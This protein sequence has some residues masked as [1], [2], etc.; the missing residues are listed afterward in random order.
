MELLDETAN[1][2]GSNMENVDTEV[3]KLQ[4]Q[5][6]KILEKNGAEASDQFL[7]SLYQQNALCQAPRSWKGRDVELEPMTVLTEMKLKC[8]W[9]CAANDTS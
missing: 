4:S 3:A 5:L 9:M 2:L 7:I 8:D 1:Y 6:K